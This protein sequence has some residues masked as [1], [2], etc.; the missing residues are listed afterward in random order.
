MRVEGGGEP[1]GSPRS[2][3][4]GV[5][6]GKHGFPRECEPK[7]SIQLPSPN[8]MSRPSSCRSKAS[9]ASSS[10]AAIERSSLWRMGEVRLRCSEVLE[11]VRGD[12]RLEATP[13]DERDL[14][15]VDP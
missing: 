7:A 10:R 4:K 1:G 5:A 3:K 15:A 12:P 6:R 14:A 13:L 2:Q 9:A 8:E 11:P